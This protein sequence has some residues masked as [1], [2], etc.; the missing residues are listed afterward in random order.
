MQHVFYLT[1]DINVT[2]SLIGHM[3]REKVRFDQK[4]RPKY[5]IVI[6]VIVAEI[7]VEI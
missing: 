4:L 6:I 7:M 1:T 5:I 2:I 3:M